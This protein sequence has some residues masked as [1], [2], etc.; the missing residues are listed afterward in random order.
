LEAYKQLFE[1]RLHVK[2][3]ELFN[4]SAEKGNVM[5]DQGYHRKIE[6]LIG[7][8]TIKGQHG[9]DRKSVV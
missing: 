7:R 4:E 9:G 8:V 6:H 3:I 2:T 1:C 5:G